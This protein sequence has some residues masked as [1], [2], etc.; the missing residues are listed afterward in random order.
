VLNAA[1]TAAEMV[2]DPRKL[3]EAD[4]ILIGTRQDSQFSLINRKQ[5]TKKFLIGTL[6]QKF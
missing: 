6:L 5:S 3:P 2:P 4:A 1:K